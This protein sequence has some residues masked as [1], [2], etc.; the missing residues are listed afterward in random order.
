MIY[1]FVKW[2]VPVLDSLKGSDVYALHEKAE[3]G[4]LDRSD[5]NTI[6][7]ELQTNS[8]SKTG[9]PRSGWMFSFKSYLK[10]FLVKLKFYGWQEVY[11]FDKSSIR[12][13]YGSDIL[14]IVLL[15]ETA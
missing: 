4:K 1:K 12:E 10:T 3:T 11:S 14:Q 15:K 5:K 13:Y 7:R 2:D 6:F 9:I 8:Y